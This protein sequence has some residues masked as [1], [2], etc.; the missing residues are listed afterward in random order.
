MV[1]LLVFLLIFFQRTKCTDA[2]CYRVTCTFWPSGILPSSWGDLDTSGINIVMLLRFARGEEKKEE[3]QL[4]V[5][6]WLLQHVHRNKLE[7]MDLT[8]WILPWWSPHSC[9]STSFIPSRT[10]DEHMSSVHKTCR[11]TNINMNFYIRDEMLL[12]RQ[13]KHDVASWEKRERQ[14]RDPLSKQI[15]PLWR[16]E[17]KFISVD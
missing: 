5:L 11:I 9:Y 1:D 8:V 6:L 3:S 10:D 4:F 13:R 7:I 12:I 15:S 2:P 14:Q 16:L 17:Y